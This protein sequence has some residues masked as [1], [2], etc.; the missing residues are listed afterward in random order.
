[1][2]T[3]SHSEVEALLSCQRKWFYGYVLGIERVKYSTAQ[4]L[5]ILGHEALDIFYTAIRE[6]KSYEVA[7]DLAKTHVLSSMSEDNLDVMRD[8]GR[9]LGYHMSVKPFA[10]YEIL[11]TEKE[12]VLEI[13]PGVGYS[14][15]VDMIVRD[16]RERIGIVDNKFVYDFFT[17]T[18]L[19]VLPQIPKYMAAL[20]AMGKPADYGMYHE[21]RYRTTKNAVPE[22]MVQIVNMLMTDTRIIRSF[23]EQLI[24]T[25]R[26]LE[27]K[28]KP[29]EELSRISLRVGNGMVCKTCSFNSICSAELSGTNPQLVVNTEYKKRERRHFSEVE[30][31]TTE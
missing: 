21:L 8:L 15:V 13:E 3:I 6:G 17:Q 4:S 9:I 7:N 25:E 19:N 16:K 11:A 20:R 30:D 29:Q 31:A 22:N 28:Q 24:A 5:G 2:V 12:F 23:E 10:D 1:M 26:I 14:F 18:V 27:L